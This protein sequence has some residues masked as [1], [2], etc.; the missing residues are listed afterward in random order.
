MKIDL[1]RRGIV[2]EPNG[3]P[4]ECEGVLNPASARTRD[5]KLLLYPRT[6]A[7][8]NISRVGIVEARGTPAINNF[9]RLGFA[10]EPKAAYE[11]RSEVGGY[12]CEDPRV[13]FIELLDLYVMM[14]AAYGPLG[15]RI[16]V[17][18]SQDAYEWQRLGL[19]KFASDLPQGA[20]KDAAFFPE[21][22]VSPQG[23]TS[24][25]FYHRPM[26]WTAPPVS[27]LDAAPAIL[28]VPPRERECVRIGYIP[29]AAIMQDL[30]N[31]LHVNESS[32]AIEPDQQWGRIKIGAGTP[33]IRTKDGW[34]SLYHG[35]DVT[36]APDAETPEVS[37]SVAA[38]LHDL[39]RPDKLLYRSPQPIFLPQ[40]SEELRGTVD[41]VVFPTAI[42]PCAD[43]PNAYDVYYG[44]A[45]TRIGLMRVTLLDA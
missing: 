11:L 26:T 30:N 34:F 22:V 16:A 9:H 15:P 5:G 24:L 21:A 41:N 45:D 23:V 32:I 3:D 27:P 12:G 37:Y 43:Q 20:D 31:I 38:V 17:A 42:D 1:E 4:S 29:L 36:I 18:I 44:M 25:A 33:P 10:L 40:T 14:Y 13:T 7:S 28:A 8:G 35:V 19:L 6:V 39:E 2:L